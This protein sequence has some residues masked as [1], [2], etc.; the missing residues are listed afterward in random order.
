[1]A[2][3]G[4]PFSAVGLVHIEN[5]IEQRRRIG[6]EEELRVCVRPTKLERHPSGRV[7]SLLT[8]VTV[9]RQKIWESAST[10]LRRGHPA[11]ESNESD[12][13]RL[14]RPTGP[15][16]RSFEYLPADSRASAEWR[17]GGDL[18]RRYAAVSGDRNPIHMHS[19]S[20]KPLG[21]PSAIAHG[22]WTKARALA[23]M[24]TRL[25]EALAVE[26]RFRKP[27]TLPTRVGFSSA[28]RGD[29][30]DFAVRD[31]KR[32]TPHLYGRVR[33]LKVKTG[34]KRAK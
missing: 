29:E 25:P 20:A 18:G 12:G 30:I 11:A 27:I 21:F 10:M 1:M 16:E 14:K 4:F 33:P 28:E 2:D 13:M 6:L 26:V 32:G 19:L 23:Q 17:L 7:F 34:R 22:M 8:E 15:P 9:G 24:D 31:A 5:R 3:G